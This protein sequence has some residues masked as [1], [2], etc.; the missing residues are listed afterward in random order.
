MTAAIQNNI[1]QLG[2]C[3]PQVIQALPEGS[4]SLLS[5][6]KLQKGLHLCS[7]CNKGQAN[8]ISTRSLCL[9]CTTDGLLIEVV[10]C[11][12]QQ[13]D[14]ISCHLDAQRRIL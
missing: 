14:G 5:L 1:H 9:T 7:Q 13:V 4:G 2:E 6:V 12:V 3:R 8:I 11:F 10:P